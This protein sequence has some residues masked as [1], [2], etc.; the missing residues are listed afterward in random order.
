MTSNFRVPRRR[1]LGAAALATLPAWGQERFPSR[2]VRLIVPYPAGGTTDLQA[3][4]IAQKMQ[5]LAGITVIVENKAGAGGN[6]GVEAVLKAP[7]DGYTIGITAMNSFAINPLLTKKLPYDVSRDVQPLTLVGSVPNILAVHPGTEIRTLKD[8]AAAARAGDI[9]YASPG[10]GTSVHLSAEMVA[11]ALQ[12]RMRHVPYRGDA[13]A[14]QDV[15]GGRVP[16][17][18]GNLPGLIEHVRAGKLRAVAITSAKRSALLPDLPTVAEQG[19]PGF[20]VKAFF[21][22]FTSRG[23]P[24]AVLDALHRD[25]FRA[26]SHPDVRKHFAKLGIDVAPSSVEALTALIYLESRKWAPIVAKT[27][28]TWD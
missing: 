23:V 1:L 26:I 11:D 3:R 12:V 6:V 10:A 17:I 15:L 2:P 24:P 19:V 22:L 14:L 7:R 21:N 4:A 27:G 18:L 9:T 5:E 25:L 13:P 28:A 16:V 8:L 20:D